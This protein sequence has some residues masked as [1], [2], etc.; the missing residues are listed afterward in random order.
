MPDPATWPVR[1]VDDDLVLR[2][3]RRRDR[4]RWQALLGANH[5]WLSPWMA[6]SPAPG[7]TMG[8]G[9]QIVAHRRAARAGDA[10]PFVV[11]V[12]GELVGAVT[13][14]PITRGSS[15]SA[16]IGYWVSRHVA[17]R[18]VAPRAVA[19]VAD[20]LVDELGMHRVEI[21]VRPENDASL[22]V[23]AKLGFPEEGR[24]RGLMFV[25]GDWRDHRSFALLAGDLGPGPG[26]VLRHVHRGGSG[27]ATGPAPPR[28]S[29]T[30]P[31]VVG[32]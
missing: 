1:L 30:G 15:W 26:A 22:R 21:D 6:G 25:D 9:E 3:L 31:E 12:A 18:G 29:G 5:E 23:V 27:P 10:L 28:G 20:H 11:E 4:R 8:V 17:G 24:R 2:G 19:L 16:S 14:Q 32:A 13:A 7:R